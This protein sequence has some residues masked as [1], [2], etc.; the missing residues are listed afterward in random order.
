MQARSN[1][2]GPDQQG[3][4][5]P[6]RRDAMGDPRSVRP[7]VTVRVSVIDGA[8][9]LVYVDV[10]DGR[11]WK[12]PLAVQEIE[13][14]LRHRPS[15]T[16]GASP[17]E[18]R[19]VRTVDM[20]RPLPSP[21]RPNLMPES[22]TPTPYSRGKANVSA[23]AV[24]SQRQQQGRTSATARSGAFSPPAQAQIQAPARSR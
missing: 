19:T 14:E 16:D 12:Q 2:N 4:R 10:R 13:N 15:A 5:V 11:G 3:A 18:P 9:R 7:E 17:S 22:K 23:N 24:R 1:V 21:D 20:G 8:D 6:L